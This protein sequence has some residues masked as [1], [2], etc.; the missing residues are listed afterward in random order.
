MKWINVKDEKPKT[1]LCCWGSNVRAG[2][3]IWKCIYIKN[4][5]VFRLDNPE[6]YEHP[7]ID[8]THWIEIPKVE[9]E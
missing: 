1:D 9:L 4:W 7:P 5:D 6:V 2:T 3:N 8:I